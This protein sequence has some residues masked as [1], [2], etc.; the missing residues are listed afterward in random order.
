MKKRQTYPKP[1]YLFY[2]AASFMLIALL[3]NL[4]NI[5][6]YINSLVQAK[7]LVIAQQ[8]VKVIIAYLEVTFP[9][10]FYAMSLFGFGYITTHFKKSD[11]F[12]AEK[13]DSIKK[14]SH[15]IEDDD[16]DIDAFLLENRK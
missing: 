7:Q 14:T 3:L 5:H 4:Y 13:H 2:A 8:L 9:Y 16:E 15:P 11:E 12:S 6:Q 10:A 1:E